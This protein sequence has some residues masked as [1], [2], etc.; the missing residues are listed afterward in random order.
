[1]EIHQDQL[2]LYGGRDGFL[3]R[4]ML[5]SAVAMPQS[6]FGGHYFHADLFEMAAA[7]LFHLV[8]NHPF[9]D[10]NKRVGA[11]AAFAFLKLNGLSLVAPEELYYQLTLSVAEG[12]TQ[13]PTIASF[14]RTYCNRD[15]E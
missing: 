8:Q 13:K 4:G 9:N 5:E 1:M 10:G 6:G 2:R 14:F 12:K 15:A 3:S 7:Y 11:V